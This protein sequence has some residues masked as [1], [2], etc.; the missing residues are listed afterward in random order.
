MT[1]IIVGAVIISFAPILVKALSIGPTASAFYRCALG[2]AVLL[3]AA[4]AKGAPGPG[5]GG[6][7]R[8]CAAAA[9]LAFSVDLFFW[10][11]S[12]LWIGAGTGTLLANTQVFHAALIGILLLGERLTRRFLASVPLA[13]LGVC[14]LAVRQGPS[15]AGDHHA[16]GV[17]CGLATGVAYAV[18][19]T[20][21]RNACRTAGGA[22]SAQTIGIASA[23]AALGLLVPAL[24]E[25]CLSLPSG[26]DWL[27]LLLLAGG[28]HV[29]GWLLISEGLSRIPV[30]KAGLILLLQPTLATLWG[31]LFYGEKLGPIQLAG[32]ALTLTAIYLGATRQR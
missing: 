28:P 7:A 8:L 17:L 20:F 13:F 26:W 14:L 25:G 31:A 10:H 27:W 16:A 30:S 22:Q 24:W 18:Y 5:A 23:F 1:G 4:R 11:R 32:A 9:G 21:L 3:C 15:Q 6:K 2:A 12:I 19:L 29:C